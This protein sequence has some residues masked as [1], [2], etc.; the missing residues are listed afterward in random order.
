MR[1]DHT[2]KSSSKRIIPEFEGLHDPEA[3]LDWERRVDKIFECYDFLEPKKV[4]LAS[5]EFKG[6]AATWAIRERVALYHFDELEDM[7]EYAIRIE[8]WL[9]ELETMS[10][11]V[12][13]VEAYEKLPTEFVATNKDSTFKVPILNIVEASIKE[14]PSVSMCLDVGEVEVVEESKPEVD[15]TNEEMPVLEEIAL[16]DCNLEV[17]SMEMTS[18]NDCIVDKLQIMHLESIVAVEK[19]EEDE[20]MME[21][22]PCSQ[23][24]DDII[25]KIDVTQVEPL[26]KHMV[27][28]DVPHDIDVPPDLFVVPMSMH[29]IKLKLEQKD[30]DDQFVLVFDPEDSNSRMNSFQEE[31]NDE[32]TISIKESNEE[33][34]FKR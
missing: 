7:V 28:K 9:E 6:Y 16:E 12:I 25:L 18:P 26:Q 22:Q 2:P 20:K 8:N 34:P 4:H 19:I 33:L 13:Q 15:M 24:E 21:L 10:K 17:S 1:H 23:T 5:L 31:G 3:Y 29:P 11:K 32:G 27:A 14:P 30:F